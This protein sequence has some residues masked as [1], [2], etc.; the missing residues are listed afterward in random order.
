M[1]HYLAWAV[2]CQIECED[3]VAQLRSM[4][5]CV[6]VFY[7]RSWREWRLCRPTCSWLQ[8]SAPTPGGEWVSGLPAVELLWSLRQPAASG[9]YCAKI[10]VEISQNTQSSMVHSHPLILRSDNWQQCYWWL[11]NKVG[12]ICT[13]SQYDFNWMNEFNLI[14]KKFIFDWS[15]LISSLFIVRTHAVTKWTYRHIASSISY[16]FCDSRHTASEVVHHQVKTC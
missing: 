14:K 8:S 1:F 16:V 9:L 10:K 3:T 6:F 13:E 4:C 2:L 15:K 5:V 7:A 11:N 12:Y